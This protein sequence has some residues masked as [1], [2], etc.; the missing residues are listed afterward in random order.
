MEAE[1][2]EN[3]EAREEPVDMA[4]RE[5]LNIIKRAALYTP[6]AVAA[7]LLVSRDKAHATPS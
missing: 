4:R 1:V 5:A 6:P 2:K 3:K 7:L